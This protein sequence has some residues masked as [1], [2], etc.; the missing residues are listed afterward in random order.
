MYIRDGDDERSWWEVVRGGSH[1]LRV[2]AGGDLAGLVAIPN[3]VLATGARTAVESHWA[4]LSV[5]LSPLFDVA[6]RGPLST[7]RGLLDT[8]P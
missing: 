4:F 2:G 7:P 6:R 1:D 5:A 8:S 3:R